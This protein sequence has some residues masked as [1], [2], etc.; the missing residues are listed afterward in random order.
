MFHFDLL[1]S[2]VTSVWSALGWSVIHFLW[3]GVLIGLFTAVLLD[4]LPREKSSP[5]YLVAS[6]AML[7]SFFCFVG[8]FLWLLTTAATTTSTSAWEL[9][10]TLL[11]PLP[12][13]SSA[14]IDVSAVAAWCWSL[15]VLFM[16]IRFARQWMWTR[17]LKT[18]SVSR[19]A[20]EWEDLFLSLRREL[21]IKEAVRF[22][23]STLVETPMLVG[24]IAPVVLVPVSTFTA[25]TPDQLRLILSHE[26]AHIRRHDHILNLV[27]CIIESILFFHPFTWWISREI[28]LEREHCC[29]DL[30]I[31]S[32]SDRR[33]LAEALTKLESFQLATPNTLLAANGGSLMNRISRIL[34]T[35]TN[36]SAT[37]LGNRSFFSG[38]IALLLV[39]IGLTTLGAGCVNNA[40]SETITREEYGR[41]AT[42]MREAVASGWLS[43]EEMTSKLGELRTQ[44]APSAND[45]RRASREAIGA[46]L[47]A[48]EEMVAKGEM[49]REDA[50][51]NIAKVRRRIAAGRAERA[52][53]AR[54]VTRAEYAAAKEKIDGM[55]AEG[56]VSREDGDT[57]LGQMRRM[58]AS[59]RSERGGEA[60]TFTR[61]EYAAAKEK[62]D[63]MVAE[64]KVSREDGDTRLGQMRRM[65][66]SDRSERGGEAKT[67]TRAEYAA[68]KEKMD[69]MV[70]AGEASQE[71][72]DTRLGQMRRMI[73]RA[74]AAPQREERRE[75]DWE[76]TKER[77][78][79]AVEAGD[80]T[81][82]QADAR[83][84][85]IKERLEL[86]EE[87]RGESKGEEF[88]W[89]S[90]KE[91]IEAAV[92]AGDITREEADAK[93]KGIE[94]RLKAGGDQADRATARMEYADAEAKIKAKVAAGEVSAEAAEKRLYKMR[95]AIE[96]KD[97]R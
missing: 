15:G 69:G 71:D 6:G 13:A 81:R 78:E 17:R 34:E 43:E 68:A 36:K 94:A 10:P 30:S 18:T 85:G 77:I 82:E 12:F 62:I 97:E 91:R 1:S 40:A 3:Q 58:I 64:G 25:L 32:K 66:A 48:I 33:H 28:R 24:W 47:D 49:S 59:D 22:L 87:K 16:S 2:S 7:V 11:N 73:V 88:D 55:V 9:Q 37:R 65:I 31:L 8:T 60:K 80:I 63:G 96:K 19:P 46:R 79:A 86:G 41:M 89:E 54:T 5:R 23:Q 93:Y 83:Y 74:D 29:D 42:Q 51:E 70:K 90:T 92:E 44:I 35:N 75:F 39:S 26:L 67:F 84:E 4:A 38:A 53:G 27:Q 72:V 50:D 61:A 20:P 21:G 14:T 95:Q 52:E 76:S 57:R 45:D 56:K